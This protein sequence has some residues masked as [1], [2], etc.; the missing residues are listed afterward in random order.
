M[1]VYVGAL[2]NLHSQEYCGRLFLQASLPEFPLLKIGALFAAMISFFLVLF[3]NIWSSLGAAVANH[4]PRQSKC[5]I[6]FIRQFNTEDL[7]NLGGP[8]TVYSG[9]YRIYSCGDQASEVISTLQTLWQVLLPALADAN[10]RTSSDAYNAFFKQVYDA[11]T[12]A[13]VI[14]N[15]TTGAAVIGAYFSGNL[16]AASPIIACANDPLKDPNTNGLLPSK[17]SRIRALALGYNNCATGQ[18]AARLIGTPIIFL[19][20]D[21]L[22]EV[23]IPSPGEC[24]SQFHSI[25]NRYTETG[26]TFAETQVRR[27]SYV[28]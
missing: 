25:T 12:V 21:F 5:C 2:K 24:M 13:A 18:S 22:N 9:R 7:F 3:L 27:I 10:S 19:C 15:I 17:S 20:E 14:S 26:G 6:S 16:P 23:L 11:P 1:M 8:D 28:P 4:L